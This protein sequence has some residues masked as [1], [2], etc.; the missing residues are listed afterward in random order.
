[1]RTS[2]VTLPLILALACSPASGGDFEGGGSIAKSDQGPAGRSPDGEQPPE[3]EP[4]PGE[5]ATEPTDS[6]DPV[7]SGAVPE[8]EVPQDPPKDPSDPPEDLQ[9]PTCAYPGGPYGVTPGSIANASF[10]WQGFTPGSQGAGVFGPTD[11]FDCDGSR[12]IHAVLITNAAGW[13]SACQDEAAQLPQ[14]MATW[15]PAGVVVVELVIETSSGYPADITMAQQW[16]E[17][18]GLHDVY[19]GAD[20]NFAFDSQYADALPFKLIVNPR[21][22][23]IVRAYTG[24]T[25]DHEVLQLAQSNH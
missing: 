24:D 15:G 25:Y 19:V 12:G 18:F 13:C 8:P 9:P 2:L 11:L 4:Q 23:T 14:R 17:V 6:G 7:D 10:T 3:G 20:P 5:P 21:D 22:M 1:M 16:R